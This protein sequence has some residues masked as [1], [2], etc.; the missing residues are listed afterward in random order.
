M[1]I[2]YAALQVRAAVKWKSCFTCFKCSNWARNTAASKWSCVEKFYNSNFKSDMMIS[3]LEV[4]CP[5]IELS[6]MFSR[7]HSWSKSRRNPSKSF[8]HLEYKPEENP[9]GMDYPSRM[10]TNTTGW[11]VMISTGS[12]NMERFVWIDFDDALYHWPCIDHVIHGIFGHTW[13][14]PT[15]PSRSVASCPPTTDHQQEHGPGVANAKAPTPQFQVVGVLKVQP[16]KETNQSFLTGLIWIRKRTSFILA[17]KVEMTWKGKLFESKNDLTGLRN[18]WQHGTNIVC[19][20][21][22]PYDP[23]QFAKA[24]FGCVLWRHPSV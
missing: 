4:L 16:Q 21:V 24:A 19:V 15:A 14:T 2:K 23:A 5:L 11:C 6:I 10:E 7:A 17:A 20:C 22:C 1:S 8:C 3:S 13:N 18:Y 12:T 9:S